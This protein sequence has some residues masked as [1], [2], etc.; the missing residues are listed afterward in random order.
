MTGTTLRWSFPVSLFC[1][2]QRHVPY[3]LISFSERRLRANVP[4]ELLKY[5]MTV[6]NS[7]RCVKCTPVAQR[8]CRTWC[9]ITGRDVRFGEKCDLCFAEM[10][11]SLFGGRDR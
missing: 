7:I 9:T 6:T 3:V 8:K 5:L 4:P 2:A 10:T 1:G 11:T